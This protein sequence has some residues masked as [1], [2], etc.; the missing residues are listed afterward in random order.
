M[1]GVSL[2][3]LFLVG[4]VIVLFYTGIVSVFGVQG[5]T[6]ISVGGTSRLSSSQSSTQS[7]GAEAGNVTELNISGRGITTHWAG[8]YGDVSGNLSL[9]DSSGNIFYDWTG[10]GEE[11]IGEVFASTDNALSWASVACITEGQIATLDTALGIIGSDPDGVEETYSS[12]TH[13][14]FSVGG[15]PLSNCNATNAY[16]NSASDAGLYYQILLTDGTDV[17]YTTLINDSGT[18]FD[19]TPY[20]FQ[21]LV[22]EP[23]SAGSTTMY[24]YIEID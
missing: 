23:D 10:L 2:K 8:F 12:T 7:T 6:G 18:G 24:F 4:M 22:G 17:I 1:K 15:I 16:S 11:V 14:G 19:N 5:A 3:K 21:L 13:P 20:D 9:G